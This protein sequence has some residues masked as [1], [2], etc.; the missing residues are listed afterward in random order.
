MGGWRVLGSVI[1]AI[2]ALLIAAPAAEATFHEMSIREVYPG[3]PDNASYVELQMWAPGQEFVGG[4][5]LVSYNSNGTVN[6]DLALPGNVASGA[7]QATILVAD[8]SYSSVFPGR[9]APDASD[10]NLNLSPAG[11]AVCWIEGSPPDC[12]AWGDF[13]GPLPT[14]I[15]ELKV[16][17]P[18]SPGGVTAV[19]ALR[20][21]IAAGC[22]TFLDPPPTDDSDDSATDFSEQEPN[23]RNN[24]TTPTEKECV[25][26]D[27]A[28][29]PPIP[30]AR[31]NS[32]SVTFEFIA[33][34]P[35]EATFECRLDAEAFAA[36]TSP[37][38]YSG[39]AGGAGTSHTFR[40]R[41]VHPVNGADGTPATVTWI[42]D[43]VAP[44]ASILTKPEGRSP[45]NSAAFTYS[46]SENGSTFRCSLAPQGE[47]DEFAPCPSTGKSYPDAEHPGPLADGVWIFKVVA[48]DQAGNEGVPEAFS[49]EVDNTLL[50]T[51]PPQTAIV[52]HP[53]DPSESTTASFTYES[54]EEGSSFECKL[55]AGGFAACS[56]AGVTY[57]GLASDSHSFQVR[58]KD[59]AGNIDPTP[60]GYS[61][62]VVAATPSPSP[63]VPLLSPPPRPNT[64]ISAKPPA[65]T[66]DRTPTFRFR[67][68]R[69]GS[70]FQCRVDGKPFKACRSPFTTNL[71]SFGRHTIAI[72]A[73]VGGATDPTPA[74]FSFKVVRK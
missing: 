64:T 68:D 31:T 27:T 66:R 59:S 8:T 9:P 57:T 20:R 73:V 17:N 65:K 52:S 3:G 28:I 58:A 18:A 61:F 44:T 47:P 24:A 54:N 56:P 53:P 41:A 33:T 22:P 67:S 35:D 2:A 34:P 40:V 71:L 72:R 42:V 38:A 4:H 51:T 21:S 62:A 37:K 63:L 16:G 13:T 39:L 6:D 29:V 45:G 7:N 69:P 70:G 23:P 32:T 48:T 30:P 55:D 36:C 46:S 74:R 14:H 12:V 43:T 25:A 11:G 26:P 60:A 5:H 1:A 10:G 50:D 49:W 15:P 19:K